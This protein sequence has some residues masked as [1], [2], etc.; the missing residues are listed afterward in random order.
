MPHQPGVEVGKKAAAAILNLQG[1]VEAVLA[2]GQSRSV[3][4]VHAAIGEGSVEAVFWILR[5]LTGN[6]RVYSA[7]AAGM[8]QQPSVQQILKAT[9]STCDQGTRL[10]SFPAPRHPSGD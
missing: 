6:E 7:R 3:S 5:H 10:T 1:Q 4:E 8:R 9:S 2:D